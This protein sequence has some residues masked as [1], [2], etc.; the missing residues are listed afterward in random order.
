MAKRSVGVYGFFGL[1][2]AT[3]VL[4]FLVFRTFHVSLWDYVKFCFGLF[5]GVYLPGQAICWLL[6]LKVNRLEMAT[7]S[8]IIGMTASTLLYRIAEIAKIGILFWAWL[9]LSAFYFLFKIV[10]NPP[11]K[12]SFSFR[13]TWVGIG[14]LGIALLVGAVLYID[15]YRNGLT[16]PDGSVRFHMHYYDGFTRSAL[17]RELSHSVP[18]QMPF[19][20]GFPISYHYDMN[21]FASFFYKYLHIG[22]FDILHRLTIT[23]Y[24]AIVIMACFI[25]I[26]VWSRSDGVALLGAFLVLFGGGGLGY[27]F[28][29]ISKYGSYWGKLFYSF[30]FIDITSIN[31]FLP[32]LAVLFAGLYCLQKYFL[33]KRTV[34]LFLGSFLLAI[35]TGYKLTF[36]V[37]L[38]A[39]LGLTAFIY[40][41]RKKTAPLYP[42]LVTGLMMSPLLLLAYLLNV[43]GPR[44]V[45]KI[46]FSNWI[47]FSLL[48]IKFMK[49][50]KAWGEFIQFTSITPQHILLAAAVLV[51]FFLG[52][53]GLAFF[54]LPSLVKKIVSSRKEKFMDVLMFSLVLCGVILF[55]WANPYLGSRTRNWIVVDIFKLSS[56]I[57]LVWWAGRI[58][59]FLKN[60][61]KALQAF[62]VLAAILLSIPN[63]VQFMWAKVYYPQTQIFDKH[64]VAT[65][66]YLNAKTDEES[67]ILHSLHVMHVCYFADRRVVLDTA[68]HSYVNFHL[69]PEQHDERY[70]D[71]ARFYENP[72]AGGDVLDKYGVSYMW[73]KKRVDLGHWDSSQFKTVDCYSKKEGELGE[74]VKT[75]SLQLVYT[76]FRHSL[77]KVEKGGRF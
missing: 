4:F 20:A 5:V 21:L 7:L 14:L 52:A 68:A 1:L 29:L 10:K 26:R 44:Y 28:G 47:V 9:G 48:E 31:P 65:C 67:V 18:P 24:F 71:V 22:V 36:A 70:G 55:F 30:Y 12:A 34:W 23:F 61:K 45:P 13:I 64:F 46:Q 74:L 43:N 33:M 54:S 51:I 49:L 40:L 39:A 62:V 77:Y 56:I 73:V 16:L 37:P 42:A 6:K 35:V 8:F 38:L 19:A 76:N 41:L 17:V 72:V 58:G 32:G 50:A 59:I 27:F 69:E 2:L 11:Q 63:T 60:K 66:Q 15:N 53:F 25:F 75:H 57:L 3:L